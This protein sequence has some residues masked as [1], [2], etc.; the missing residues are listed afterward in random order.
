MLKEGSKVLIRRGKRGN[1]DGQIALDSTSLLM[2]KS[3]TGMS[4]CHRKEGKRLRYG[5]VEI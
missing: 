5:K 1:Q 4:F 2:A 3:I